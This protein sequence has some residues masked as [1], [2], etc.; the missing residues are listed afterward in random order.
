MKIKKRKYGNHLLNISIAIALSIVITFMFAGLNWQWESLVLNVIYGSVIGLSIAFGCGFISTRMI[1][2]PN[3]LQNPVRSFVK[4]ILA[5]SL[6]IIIDVIIF[7]MIWFKVTQDR[8]VFEIFQHS[9]YVLI[10][11]LEFVIGIIIYLIILSKN[12]ALRLNDYY[13]NAEESKKEL[14]KYKFETLKNQV[15]PHFLFNSLNVLS[16]MI[17]KDLD[18]ADDFIARLANIY[19]YVLDIQ[20]EEV[21]ELDREIA[22][23]KDFLFL[24]SL[25]YGNNFQFEIQ[26]DSQKYIVPMSIQII[27]ENILKHNSLSAENPLKISITNNSNFL[28]ISNNLNPVENPEVSHGLGLKNVKKRYQYLTDSEI[29]IEND[30]KFFTVKLPFLNLKN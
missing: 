27:V 7:N 16:G 11:C 24:L 30:G 22:F 6:Y 12:F 15:N 9:F 26:V 2:R 10:L 28:I 25:R 5:V 23:V 20:D 1:A 13:V 4:T 17:Y 29:Q 19:R 8:G 21:I 14:A 3:W 18:K